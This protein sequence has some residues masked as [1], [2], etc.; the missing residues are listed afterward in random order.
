MLALWPFAAS[1]GSC[2]AEHPRQSML[3]MAIYT[4]RTTDHVLTPTRVLLRRKWPE[5]QHGGPGHCWEQ[6]RRDIPCARRARTR[7]PSRTGP[8]A[9]SRRPE[10]ARGARCLTGRLMDASR[11]SR[12]PAQRSATV[13]R[14]T[15]R[16]RICHLEAMPNRCSAG[17]SAPPWL[18]GREFAPRRGARPR[19]R[20]INPKFA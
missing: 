10:R 7:P 14:A 20:Y 16:A 12:R 19:H 8:W 9:G 3:V 15:L 4:A 17:G 6:L 2:R 11:W 5:S 18:P 13:A 1:R